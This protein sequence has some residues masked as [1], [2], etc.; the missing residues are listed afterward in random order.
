MANKI[1]LCESLVRVFSF[2]KEKTILFLT[3]KTTN[4]IIYFNKKNHA[5]FSK[6]MASG[7]SDFEHAL[8][9]MKQNSDLKKRRNTLFEDVSNMNPLNE[10]WTRKDVEYIANQKNPIKRR[11]ALAVEIILVLFFLVCLGILVFEYTIWLYSS[12]PT[13]STPDYT[14][15]KY[16]K[17]PVLYQKIQYNW[18]QDTLGRYENWKEYRK[19]WPVCLVITEYLHDNNEEYYIIFVK[20]N[21]NG[22]NTIFG[23]NHAELSNNIDRYLNEV[24]TFQFVNPSMIAY[25]RPDKMSTYQP[26]YCAVKLNTNPESPD[27]HII[28]ALN[29][30]II[31]LYNPTFAYERKGKQ[32][33]VKFSYSFIETMKRP[34][35]IHTNDRIA[36]SFDVLHK[37]KPLE[38]QPLIFS[39]IINVVNMAMCGNFLYTEEFDP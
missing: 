23:V 35:W 29:S 4:I 39:D 11:L 30:S 7:L 21:D 22:K 5:V 1:R 32:I 20:E 19:E 12:L 17:E 14:E 2:F 3:I 28:S 37:S 13:T 27:F 6:K 26:C 33:D 36:V 38:R 31:H 18:F 24:E 34:F 10:T 8:T 25:P 16:R 9:G 15:S